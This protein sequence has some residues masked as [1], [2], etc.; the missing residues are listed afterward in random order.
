MQGELF[1]SRHVIMRSKLTVISPSGLIDEVMFAHSTRHKPSSENV[2]SQGASA[3]K[4]LLHVK[5]LPSFSLY[6]TVM[7][8]LP[9]AVSSPFLITECSH[10]ALISR[11]FDAVP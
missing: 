3:K 8:Q 11:T 7:Q 10:L 5:T 4:R 9:A 1:P 2:D 6:I